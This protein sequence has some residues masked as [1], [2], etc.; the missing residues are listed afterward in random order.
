MAL[1]KMALQRADRAIHWDYVLSLEGAQYGRYG[2]RRAGNGAG[3][4]R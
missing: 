2:L 3:T 1:D 4:T